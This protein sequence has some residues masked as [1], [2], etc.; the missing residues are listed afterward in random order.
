LLWAVE[1]REGIRQ[2]ELA[3]ALFTDP[4]TVTAM[5]ARLEKRGLVRRE[6]CADDG[7]ARRVRLTA[8]GRRMTRRL[9]DDWQPMRQ[10][11]QEVFAGEVGQEALR[12]LDEVRELMTKSRLQILEKQ[13]VGRKRTG[14]GATSDSPVPT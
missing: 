3:D 9:S 10:K 2:N 4:N 1:K 7:R 5:L 14:K 12:V 6:V 8:A 11:L 13:S